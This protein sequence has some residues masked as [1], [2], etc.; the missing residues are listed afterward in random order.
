MSIRAVNRIKDECIGTNFLV[1][2]VQMG[3]R[4]YKKNGTDGRRFLHTI[5]MKYS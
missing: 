2:T 1:N 3:V 4:P 5:P